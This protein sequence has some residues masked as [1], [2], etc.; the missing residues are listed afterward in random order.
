M[1]KSIWQY[2]TGNGIGSSAGHC[3]PKG[4]KKHHPQ[5]CSSLVIVLLGS[6]VCWA[7]LQPDGFQRTSMEKPRQLQ[8]IKHSGSDKIAT[9]LTEKYLGLRQSF[10]C[11]QLLSKGRKKEQRETVEKITLFQLRTLVFV[12]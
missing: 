7:R 9:F 8:L 11:P 6:E 12:G 10:L 4:R 3:G 1:H 5:S 2:Q